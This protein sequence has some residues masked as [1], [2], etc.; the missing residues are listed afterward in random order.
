MKSANH[1]T[2]I[3]EKNQIVE[4]IC[5][6]RFPAILSIEA[7]EPADFQDTIRSH[8]PRYGCRE[9]TLPAQNGG[10]RQTMKNH[11]FISADGCWKLSLTKEFIALSTMRYPGWDSFAHKLDE[12]LCQFIRVYQPAFFERVGLR[13]LNGFSRKALDLENCRWNELLQPKYLGILDDDDIDESAIGKCAVEA[14]QKL[15]AECNLKIHAG[16]GSIRRSVVTEK[17]LQTVQDPEVRFILDI[18]FFSGGQTELSSVAQ[19]LEALH[20]HADRIFSDA[21]TDVLHEAMCPVEL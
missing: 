20:T 19:R 2:F 11:S 8:F 10:N 9:E 1:K 5:Q 17:G 21:I 18:D 4:T 12:V 3:Y 16:P 14:E 7:K 15:D 13:Y 6:L